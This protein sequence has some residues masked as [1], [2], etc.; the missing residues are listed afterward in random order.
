MTYNASNP[1]SLTLSG[2]YFSSLLS[3]Y[4]LL[5]VTYSVVPRDVDDFFTQAQYLD[6]TIRTT[7]CRRDLSRPDAVRK[8]RKRA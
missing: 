7:P 5:G 1:K 2:K 6:T 8:R 4:P 3:I